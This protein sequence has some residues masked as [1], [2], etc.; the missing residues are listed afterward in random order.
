MQVLL[1]TPTEPSSVH[2]ERGRR[3]PLR[4]CS[5]AQLG[6]TPRARPTLHD[7]RAIRM[8]RVRSPAYCRLWLVEFPLGSIHLRQEKMAM[9][10][11]LAY[12]RFG[13]VYCGM[14]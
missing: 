6:D 13:L 4:A 7:R 2:R 5:I 12:D 11:F 3:P 9:R 14:G 1:R 8:G 10:L